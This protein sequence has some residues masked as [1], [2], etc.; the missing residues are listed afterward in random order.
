MIEQQ[1]MKRW[2]NKLFQSL[3]LACCPNY[4]QKLV[5]SQL[6][7]RKVKQLLLLCIPID[8]LLNAM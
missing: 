4:N 6:V 1:F 5:L 8:I 3:K 2:N 7:I